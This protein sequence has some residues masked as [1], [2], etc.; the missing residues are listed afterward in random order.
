MQYS[1]AG[2]W[3]RVVAFALDYLIIAVYLILVAAVGGLV[4]LAFP[5]LARVLFG[6]RIAG[7]AIGFALVTLPVMLYFALLESS[8][9]QASWG[10]RR[11]G[12]RVVDARGGWLSLAHALARTALAFAPWELSHTLIWQLHFTTAESP[13]LVT[14]GFILVWLLVGA[15]T[16]NLVLRPSHQ[17]LYDWLAGTHVVAANDG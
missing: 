16:V 6:N 4:N 10:K 2:L 14:A 9:W 11:L 7:Q 13:A 1:Y 12:L 8:V 15:N 3:A 5:G 17:T